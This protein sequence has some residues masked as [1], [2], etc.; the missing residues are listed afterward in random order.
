MLQQLLKLSTGGIDSVIKEMIGAAKGSIKGKM[1]EVFAMK[2][3]NTLKEKIESIGKVKSILYPDAIVSLET[4]Y[5]PPAASFF[6]DLSI[7]SVSKFPLKHVLIE[8]GPGQG[9]SLFLRHLCLQ[10]A[11]GGGLIPIFVE[12]RNLSFKRSLKA[13]L[14][15]SI[16]EWGIAIDESLFDYL[17]R[18]ERIVYLLDGFDEI[19]SHARP[20]VARE[21]ESI[22]KSFPELRV[23]VSSR[24][25][26]G[27]GASVYYHK[28]K[29]APL[30]QKK[31]SDFINHIY[32]DKGQAQ[33]TIT[34]LEDSA[35]IA[36]VTNTPLLLTLFAITYNARQFR[37]DSISEFYNL[38]FPTMLYRHDRMKLGYERERKAGLT[39][40]QMQRLFDTLSFIS[41][42]NDMTRFSAANFR[43]FIET[44][45]KIERLNQDIEDKL[46][47]DITS[48]TAL[49]IPDGFDQFSYTHKSIQEYFAAAFIYRLSESKKQAFY[50]SLINSAAQYAQWENVLSFLET[51]DNESYQRFYMIPSRRQVIEAVSSKNISDRVKSASLLIG[52]DSKIKIT[53]NGELVGAFWGDVYI[54]PAF[55]E[56]SRF[57]QRAAL[58][59]FDGQN[60][61]LAEYIE[62]CP[63]NEYESFRIDDGTFVVNIIR[64]IEELN[65]E[66]DFCLYISKAF[67]D[68]SI[69]AELSMAEKSLRVT[70]GLLDNLLSID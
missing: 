13:E 40:Y 34:V 31:Q 16:Q 57:A 49:I 66:K 11:R 7:E 29:I 47:D 70:E 12:F 54:S 51:I 61:R 8:G 26:A 3:I 68:S 30:S 6:D 52:S 19:P 5:F 56:Y 55:K 45:T 25:N 23:I 67:A 50:Q 35:F 44:S 60:S 20:K 69:K 41:L 38:I 28:F 39:D 15:E 9:K 42:K 17:A 58:G 46:I 27:M 2:N 65:L 21:L 37:P 18:S 63:I 14:I 33:A 4:I 32:S 1:A 22:A 36:E 59:F 62:S 53:E 64:F 43:R 24:P 10:E 48:I